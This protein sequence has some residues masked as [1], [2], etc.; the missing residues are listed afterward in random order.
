V[1]GAW[2]RCR[3]DGFSRFVPQPL[4]VIL[5]AVSQP[6]RGRARWGVPGRDGDGNRYPC[7]C[8]LR[9]AGTT[10]RDRRTHVD[11]LRVDWL[12][13]RGWGVPG[14]DAGRWRRPGS[15]CAALSNTW[16][17]GTSLIRNSA[18]LGSYSGPYGGPR[19][20]GVP[21]RGAGRRG[22]LR[23]RWWS[24]LGNFFLLLYHSQA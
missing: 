5:R 16:Y 21:G 18:P 1:W 22:C 15:G 10:S 14:R 4:R 6:N 13:V 19:G 17:R 3:G 2:P 7:K 11:R 24:H 23:Y 9:S 20:W 8:P 12:T